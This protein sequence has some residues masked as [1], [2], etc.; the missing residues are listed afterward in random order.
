MREVKPFEQETP[1]KRKEL[2]VAEIRQRGF[3]AFEGYEEKDIPYLVQ[4]LWDHKSAMNTLLDTIEQ[5]YKRLGADE[6]L[7]QLA[8]LREKIQKGLS[9]RYVEGVVRMIL[10]GLKEE[11]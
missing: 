10:Q 7:E 9:R 11:G 1:K 2:S 8:D 5:A 6:K 3:R 4:F